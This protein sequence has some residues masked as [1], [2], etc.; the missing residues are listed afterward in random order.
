M[1]DNNNNRRTIKPVESKD[2][3]NDLRVIWDSTHTK[4][5]RDN[6]KPTAE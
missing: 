3:H 6:R 5:L 2:P 4:I 1:T